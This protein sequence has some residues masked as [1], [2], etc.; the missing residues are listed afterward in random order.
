MIPG[1]SISNAASELPVPV[2]YRNRIVSVGEF[3]RLLYGVLLVVVSAH[4]PAVREDL[5]AL[6]I[7]YRADGVG[8]PC[9]CRINW[10]RG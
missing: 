8:R 1:E 9:H 5:P 10:L 2:L 6:R 3:T 4:L 7:R